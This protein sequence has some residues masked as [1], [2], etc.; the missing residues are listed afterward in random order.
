MNRNK[1]ICGSEQVFKLFSLEG[2]NKN[3]LKCKKCGLAWTYPPP[4]V[5]YADY[6]FS[7]HYRYKKVH[8]SRS[9]QILRLT[10]CFKKKGK[11]LELGCGP[12][13]L[14]E[15]ARERGFQ[16]NGIDLCDAAVTNAQRLLGKDAVEKKDGTNPILQNKANDVIVMDN[17]LEHVENFI[18]NLLD[19]EPLL[20]DRGI[21]VICS[22]NID[23]LYV[24]LMKEDSSILKPD[25]H[26]WQ[27]SIKYIKHM[28]EK[29][30]YVPLRIK[31]VG[32]INIQLFL[33]EL[34]FLVLNKRSIKIFLQNSLNCIFGYLGCGDTFILVAR[35]NHEY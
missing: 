18:Q 28:L 10:R 15:L 35:K 13:L 30:G 11:L 33:H 34:R 8:Q 25:E 29:I 31:P 14:L 21:I 1:C 23:G 2:K 17:Y 32:F 9:K 5:D 4:K 3:I 27:F 24:K 22:P 19:I 12:G 16:V 6:D 20:N 7:D 26:I